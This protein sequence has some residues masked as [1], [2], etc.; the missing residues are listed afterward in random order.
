MMQRRNLIKAGA[1]SA[2]TATLAACG[3]GS[4]QT[5]GETPNP[6]PTL[7]FIR[8]RMA[9]SWPKSLDIVFGTADQICRRVG[10]MTDGRFAITPYAAGEIVPGLDVLEAVRSQEVE[11]GHTAAYYY[12]EQNPALAFATTVP[13]GLNAQQQTAWLYRGGGLELMQ[14]LYADFRVI[15]FPAGST[16]A[17]MGGWFQKEIQAISDLKGLKMRIPGLGG[18]VMEALGV[19][20]Q[21][22]PGDEIFAALERGS[23]DAAEWV[24]PYEDE[25][26]G[27][28]RVAPIYYY[29]GWWEPGTTYEVQINLDSWQSLPREYQEILRTA[30]FEA[31][32]TMLAEYDSVNGAALQR[33]LQLGTQLNRYSNEILEAAQTAAFELYEADADQDSTFRQVYSQWKAFREQVYR[34]NRLNELSFSSFASGGSIV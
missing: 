30:I 27:L 7:P 29:P 21:V 34:W 22:L 10:E 31:H 18:Q 20:V 23:I 24:G 14:K 26:L 3:Q 9:T 32:T 12:V 2:A 8:W 15:N 1:L 16:G 33:L 6:S 13:F 5:A 4:P 11:C 19:D 17:Q 28:N 25:K